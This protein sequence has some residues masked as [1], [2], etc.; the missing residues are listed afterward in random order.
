MAQRFRTL[1]ALTKDPSL[2]LGTHIVAHKQGLQLRDLT[3]S[4]RAS[5]VT[6]H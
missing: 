1:V 4:L 5:T 3:H 2:V 6:K